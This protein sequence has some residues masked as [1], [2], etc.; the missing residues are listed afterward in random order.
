M[1]MADEEEKP[2][3]KIIKGAPDWMVT[4]GDMMTLMLCFFVLLFAMS[5]ISPKKFKIVSGSLRDR[6]LSPIPEAN[7]PPAQEPKT[8]DLI[9]RLEEREYPGGVRRLKVGRYTFYIEN[10]REGLMITI[11]GKAMFEIGSFRL[12]S[13]PLTG[14][15]DPDVTSAL[16]EL[17]QIC[18]DTRNVIEV[19]GHTSGQAEEEMHRTHRVGVGRLDVGKWDL[20]WYRALSVVEYLTEEQRQVDIERRTEIP[21][22]GLDKGRFFVAG[23]SRNEPVRPDLFERMGRERN[24]RVEI[25]VR[26]MH[27]RAGRGR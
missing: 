17:M 24:R 22:P 14:E 21:I 11:G 23:S 2:K 12:R 10:V 3:L 1:I 5:V 25:V 26:H 4:Y 16:N 27:I 8:T 20:S 18:R 19:R 7:Y 15:I 13:N 9:R 6:L